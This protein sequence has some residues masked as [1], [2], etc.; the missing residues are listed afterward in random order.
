[1]FGF[2]GKLIDSQGLY[3]FGEYYVLLV[4]AAV[5]STPLPGLLIGG[6][7]RAET[8]WGIALYRLGEKVIPA[9]LLLLSIAVIVDGT[10]NPFL[11]FRF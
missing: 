5:A 6:L 9:L 10:F 3:L 4:I 8:G 11:Y 7:E 2:G 1:M